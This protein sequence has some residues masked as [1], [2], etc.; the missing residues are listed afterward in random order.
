MHNLFDL[1]DS[2]REPTRAY[3]NLISLLLITSVPGFC[4]IQVSIPDF[5]ATMLFADST[6]NSTNPIFTKLRYQLYE[7][8]RKEIRARIGIRLIG[9]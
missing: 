1:S 3:A 2:T 5:L 7:Y 8:S 9:A 6:P 4:G